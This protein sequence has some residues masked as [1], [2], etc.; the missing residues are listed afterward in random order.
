MARITYLDPIAS[1]T[2]RLSRKGA[3]QIISRRKIYRDEYGNVLFEGNSESYIVKHPR[4]FDK[5]PL[6]PGE[7]KNVETFQQAYTQ[8][9]LEKQNPE[10]M[11]YWTARYRAQL[12]KGDPDAP[13]DKRTGERRIYA[14]LDNFIRAMIQIA[15]RKQ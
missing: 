8:F 12:D 3:R 4:D 13:V 1:M 11:A 9:Q 15:L 6:T 2:G 10:R 14:R 5:K 7:R